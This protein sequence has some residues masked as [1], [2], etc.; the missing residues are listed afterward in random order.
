MH[1]HKKREKIFFNETYMIQYFRIIGG[2][3]LHTIL[4]QWLG[5]R[6]AKHAKC[7]IISILSS[8]EKKRYSLII[9]KLRF[10]SYNQYITKCVVPYAKHPVLIF[11][12]YTNT[13]KKMIKL[14]VAENPYPRVGIIKI[15][16]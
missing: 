5:I 14:E 7:L 13:T 8:S 10:L 1:L 12:N 16:K 11:A 2:K 4:M 6:I 3:K 15:I 9:S